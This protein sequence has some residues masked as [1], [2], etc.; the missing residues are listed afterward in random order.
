MVRGLAALDDRCHT[1]VELRIPLAERLGPRHV[2]LLAPL[3]SIAPDRVLRGGVRDD[4]EGRIKG[5]SLSGTV[6]V[7]DD[8]CLAS[9][10]S[11]GEGHSPSCVKV[12]DL[13][14]SVCVEHDR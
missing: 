1:D 4:S 10:S 9:T 14:R 7:G 12:V 13:A 6:I 2:A 8:A 11:T 3:A 5:S